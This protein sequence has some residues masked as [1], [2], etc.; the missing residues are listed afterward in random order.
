MTTGSSWNGDPQFLRALIEG[1]LDVS[2][3]WPTCSCGC[4]ERGEPCEGA[5]AEDA[6]IPT[7][8][9]SAPKEEPS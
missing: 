5:E 3:T 6:T 4:E 8:A 1:K 7:E 2:A 9:A